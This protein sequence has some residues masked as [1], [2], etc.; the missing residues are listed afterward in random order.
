MCSASKPKTVGG[1]R[2]ESALA[3]C[4]AANG[5]M[6]KEKVM[7]KIRSS[8][9]LVGPKLRSLTFAD[10]LLVSLHLIIPFYFRSGHISSFGLHRS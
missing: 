3:R 8:Q 9:L 1:V 7:L 2:K 10:K 5:I 4:P 6:I